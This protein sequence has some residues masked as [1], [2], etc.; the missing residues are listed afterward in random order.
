MTV[1]LLLAGIAGPAL[2]VGGFL[3]MGWKRPGYKPV[4]T[5]ASQLALNGG[6]W[7]WQVVNVLAGLFMVGGG[8]GLHERATSSLASL[9]GCGVIVGGLGFVIFGTSRDDAWLLYPPGVGPKGISQPKSPHGWGH[10]AGAIIAFAGLESAHVL[11]ACGFALQG[12]G[13]ASAYSVLTAIVFPLVYAAAVVSAVASWL[14]WHP[15]GGKAGLLQKTSLT[16]SLAWVA[17][18][19]IATVWSTGVTPPG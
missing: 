16:A 19:A 4:Y 5:F 12:D 15:W 6:G 17:V 14:P 7:K 13:W 3:Y 1:W 2:F 18:L 8:F 9:G 10:Q 11:Y